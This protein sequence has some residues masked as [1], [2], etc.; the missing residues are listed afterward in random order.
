M[1]L[2]VVA[3]ISLAIALAGYALRALTRS[4]GVAAFFV[5]VACLGYG[6]YAVAVPLLAFFVSGSTLSRLTARSSAMR[7]AAK[8]ATRDAVQVFANGGAPAFAAL[9][10]GLVYNGAGPSAARWLAASACAIASATADTWATEIGSRSTTPP[11]SIA[12][13]QPVGVG[14]SGGVTPLGTLASL[15]G[16]SLIGMVYAAF[17]PVHRSG[18][19]AGVMS[20]GFIG[21]LLDSILGASL[22]GVWRCDSC[23][24]DCETRMHAC[25]ARTRLVRG[26]PWLDNDGVNAIS[27]IA[28]AVLGYYAFPSFAP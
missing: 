16:A 23:A 6:G 21:A 3:L 5:G 10:A 27:T 15:A 17:L 11:R 1:T 9:I 18:I 4:G 8:G 7:A 14:A 13:W 28:G 19:A 20:I 2:A 12:T 25:G 24:T 26:A 22:Q